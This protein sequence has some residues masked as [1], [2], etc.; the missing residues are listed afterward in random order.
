MIVVIVLITLM[1]VACVSYEFC[2]GFFSRCRD[3]EMGDEPRAAAA[4]TRRDAP[5]AA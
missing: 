4:V 1:V 3:E 5:P 2:L